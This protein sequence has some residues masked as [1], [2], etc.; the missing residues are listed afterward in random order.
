MKN[1]LGPINFSTDRRREKRISRLIKET[2]KDVCAGS[3]QDK[4][5]K[6]DGVAYSLANNRNLLE[7]DFQTFLTNKNQEKY[8]QYED[9]EESKL[10]RLSMIN[11]EKEVVNSAREGSAKPLN[12]YH[13]QSPKSHEKEYFENKPRNLSTSNVTSESHRHQARIDKKI[14]NNQLNLKTE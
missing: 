4:K 14:F 2:I 5:V 3:K 1:L 8:R 13:F 10:K 6:E 9:P 11:P 12:L 7:S